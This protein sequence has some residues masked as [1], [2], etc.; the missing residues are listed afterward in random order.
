M[1]IL[2]S[3]SPRRK[4]LIKKL[5]DEFKVVPADIDEESVVADPYE[6][7]GI[8]SSLKAKAVFKQ[9]PNDTILAWDT[10]VILD[11][12][13]MGK[14]HSV[15]EASKMLHALSGKVHDVVSGYTLLS[16]DRNITRTVRTRVYFNTLSDEL[17][18]A[19]IKSGSPMD[20]AGAYGIQDKEFN[21]VN[22]IEGSMDNVIGFP[23]EDIKEHC[24]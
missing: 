10:V 2:A 16:K 13:E 23:T 6:L 9:Y 8:L 19:Y 17:I 18:D 11:G 7:P 12:I 5:V 24:F 20:K 22:K 21:L 1:I 3:Q 4:E 15:E 14:P